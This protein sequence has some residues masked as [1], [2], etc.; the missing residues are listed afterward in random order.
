[1]CHEFSYHLLLLVGKTEI[2]SSRVFHLRPWFVAMATSEAY[3]SVAWL[4]NNGAIKL[5]M[6]RIYRRQISRRLFYK[7]ICMYVGGKQKNKICVNFILQ[8]QEKV[9]A[10]FSVYSTTI[11]I[12]F[13]RSIKNPFIKWK[14][15]KVV[16][17][18]VFFLECLIF[19]VQ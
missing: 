13:N 9:S 5:W 12:A 7:Y 15:N 4:H 1:M 11:L 10:F 14:I 3:R 6:K 8:Q 18:S 16:S 2:F 19:V 17:F